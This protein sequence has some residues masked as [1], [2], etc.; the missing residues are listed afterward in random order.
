MIVYIYHTSVAETYVK[1]TLCRYSVN[2]EQCAVY[3]QQCCEH[4]GY[5]N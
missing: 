5:W 2:P 1:M 4:Y 3:Q